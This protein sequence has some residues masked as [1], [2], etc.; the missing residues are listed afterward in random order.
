MADQIDLRGTQGAVVSPGSVVQN[1]ESAKLTVEDRLGEQGQQIAIL[2]EQVSQVSVQQERDSV[3]RAAFEASIKTAIAEAVETI[4]SEVASLK[5]L[6]AILPR[7]RRKTVFSL[8]W[9]LLFMPVPL[10]F[11]NV[12]VY[13]GFHWYGAVLVSAMLYFFSAVL[14]AYLFGLFSNQ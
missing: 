14:F 11:D 9:L 4:R 2:N 5:N 3:Q 8:A 12:L 7:E 13:A 6:A 1:Y 10:F